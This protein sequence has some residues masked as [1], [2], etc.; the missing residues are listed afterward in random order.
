[1]KRD[2]PITAA[3]FQR[4]HGGSLANLSL[5]RLAKPR[6]EGSALEETLLDQVRRI[7]LPD[8]EREVEFHPTRKWRF[9]FLWR[10][11]RLAVECEGATWSRGRHTRGRGF[12]EDCRK[13]NEAALLEY[14]L[15]R[16]TAGMIESGEA[17]TMIERA[18]KGGEG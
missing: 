14:R 4:R 5:A 1:M 10:E 17:L 2:A 16:F 6:R 18:L 7:G 8:P 15:L 13:Y 12:E 3:E 11:R 9:D